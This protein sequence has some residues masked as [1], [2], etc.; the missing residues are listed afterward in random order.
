LAILPAAAFQA[1]GLAA[2]KEGWRI[3]PPFGF[4]CVKSQ[5]LN[6]LRRAFNRRISAF[7]ELT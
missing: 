4:L 1:A 2:T 6:F 5:Q 7:C 3:R